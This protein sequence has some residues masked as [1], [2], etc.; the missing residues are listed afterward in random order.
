MIGNSF[1]IIPI[2]LLLNYKQSFIKEEESKSTADHR[3]RSLLNTILIS[4]LPKP[5]RRLVI[6]V[7]VV[8]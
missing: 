1:S 3:G 8:V 6:I 7:G 5:C 2:L 4:G